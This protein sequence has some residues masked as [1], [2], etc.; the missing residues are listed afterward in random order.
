MLLFEPETVF[1]SF[2]DHQL[3]MLLVSCSGSIMERGLFYSHFSLQKHCWLIDKLLLKLIRMKG[4]NKPNSKNESVPDTRW[5]RKQPLVLS[6]CW[7][8][9]WLWDFIKSS[10]KKRN[11]STTARGAQS[12]YEIVS[13]QLWLK[14]GGKFLSK[15]RR[16]TSALNK[17]TRQENICVCG[18]DDEADEGVLT[19]CQ[20][21]YSA[22]CVVYLPRSWQKNHLPVILKMIVIVLIMFLGLSPG[23]VNLF[24]SHNDNNHCT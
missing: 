2:L 22:W 9:L 4:T 13:I 15:N 5:A 17:T 6:C 7:F 3:F 18:T 20:Y 12:H 11:S 14:F 1:L 19:H 24:S 10:L 23:L 16:P 8:P 21:M